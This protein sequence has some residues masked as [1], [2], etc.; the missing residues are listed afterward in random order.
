VED[1]HDSILNTDRS[2][3]ET[4]QNHNIEQTRLELNQNEDDALV[5]DGLA[6]HHYDHYGAPD[7]SSSLIY[8]NE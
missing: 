6:M 5:G 7:D 2:C 3:F 1:S 4:N 8:E